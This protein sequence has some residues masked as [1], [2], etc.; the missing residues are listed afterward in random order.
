MGPHA[1]GVA[2]SSSGVETGPPAGPRAPALT[3][4]QGRLRGRLLQEDHVLQEGAV[5]SPAVALQGR[6]AQVGSEVGAGEQGDPLLEGGESQS[7]GFLLAGR[8]LERHN[9]DARP[10][11]WASR[12]PTTHTRGRLLT[13]DGPVAGSP[14]VMLGKDGDV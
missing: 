13:A 12:P 5:R 4:D 3:C 6:C 7:L 1:G 10:R 11:A 9:R 8:P 2:G 14:S